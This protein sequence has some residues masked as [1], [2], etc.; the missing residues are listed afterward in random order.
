MGKKVDGAKE[1]LVPAESPKSDLPPKGDLARRKVKQQEYDK[2]R[3]EK[4]RKLREDA[5][6][7]PD[8]EHLVAEKVAKRVAAIEASFQQKNQDMQCEHRRALALAERNLET[9]RRELAFVER[10]LKWHENVRDWVSSVGQDCAR[11]LL[12]MGVDW[13]P[14][15]LKMR[16]EAVA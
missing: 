10:Q 3:R 14:P 12:K 6:K 9:L 4:I 11:I 1:S 7:T 13:V 8:V 5:K 16:G 2:T 15:Y